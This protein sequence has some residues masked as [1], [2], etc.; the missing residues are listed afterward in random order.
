MEPQRQFE[1]HRSW[2]HRSTNFCQQNQWKIRSV[3]KWDLFRIPILPI[4]IV[5]LT[6]WWSLMRRV[7]LQNVKLISVLQ[8][9]TWK[10]ISIIYHH[11]K[12]NTWFCASCWCLTSSC[13]SIMWAGYVHHVTS[14]IQTFPLAWEMTLHRTIDPMDAIR[15]FP[16]VPCSVLPKPSASCNGSGCGMAKTICRS[17]VPASGKRGKY[18]LRIQSPLVSH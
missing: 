10:S 2:F 4:R 9:I 14:S 7:C 17:E 6:T 12:N 18:T 11:T 1:R 3:Q 15:R 13:L 16:C 8:V 5:W